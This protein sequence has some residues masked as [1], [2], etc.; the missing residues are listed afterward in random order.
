MIKHL[1]IFTGYNSN[2]INRIRRMISLG[3]IMLIVLLITGVITGWMVHSEIM[4]T[5]TENYTSLK[6]AGFE[7][8]ITAP[9]VVS[10]RIM[11]LLSIIP[12]M[13]IGLVFP[14]VCKAAYELFKIEEDMIKCIDKC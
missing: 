5:Y 8:L 14:V 7:Q 6:N 10:D 1:G 11:V 2:K 9:Q 3:V 13:G 4:L 12:L